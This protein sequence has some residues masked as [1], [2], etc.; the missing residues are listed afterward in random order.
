MADTNPLQ[1]LAVHGVF[2]RLSTQEQLT[3]YRQASTAVT[4]VVSPEPS[5]NLLM[6]Q[7]WAFSRDVV[8]GCCFPKCGC[9]SLCFRGT[10]R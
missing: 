3:Q 6:L 8:E 7:S 4:K 1:V 10:L 2:T 9:L 5:I